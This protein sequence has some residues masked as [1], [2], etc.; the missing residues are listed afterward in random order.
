LTASRTPFR[1]G[2]LD[3][4]YSG[5]PEVKRDERGKRGGVV[6]GR[7]GL[8]QRLPA[9]GWL[10][11]I[12][13]GIVVLSVASAVFFGSLGTKTYGARADILYVAA[14]DTSDDARNRILAT[15]QELLRSRV[16]LEDVS[17]SAAIPLPELQDAVSVDVGRDDLLHLTV[18]DKDPR[19]AQALAAI[20]ASRYVQLTTRLSPEE[21]AGRQLI[22]SKID[23]LTEGDRPRTRAGRDRVARL[24]DRL[25]DLEVQNL[26]RPKAE[27]LS[28]A[29]VLDGPLSPKPLRAGAL[30][31]L[32][33]LLIATA[34]VVAM[35]RRDATAP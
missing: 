29:Y 20:V 24:R 9:W 17:R 13:V 5:E 34:V 35:L 14:D 27:L 3:P 15:Q 26:G 8:G 23:R 1:E 4:S 30:G 16:V 18:A 6:P 2:E 32:I 33:G 12:A 25:V 31:L 10:A 21:T 7:G 28:R 19:R 11:L 22:Q